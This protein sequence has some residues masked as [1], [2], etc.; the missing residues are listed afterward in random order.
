MKNREK[1]LGISQGWYSRSGEYTDLE[2]DKF[3]RKLVRNIYLKHGILTSEAYIH[4]YPERISIKFL[5][6]MTDSSQYKIQSLLM[7]LI[8]SILVLKY[9]KNINIYYKQCPHL[10]FNSSILVDYLEQKLKGN[11]NKVRMILKK[12]M[13]KV[14]TDLSNKK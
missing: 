1:R 14:N 3:I 8:K 13:S 4:R 6:Y 11:S 2:S 12:L 5:M 10:L 9:N 7:K